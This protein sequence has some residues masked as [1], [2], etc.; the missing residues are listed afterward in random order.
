MTVGRSPGQN[1]FRLANQILD[2]VREA[3]FE[4]GHHLRE[5]QLGD[6]LG[7]SRTPVRMALALLAERG[8]V[9][10]RRN[11]GY[12]LVQP[13]DALTRIEFEVPASAEQDL[14]EK[15]VGD[16]IA[17][18]IPGSLTQSEIARR[19][20]VDRAVMLRTLARLAEDGLVARNKGHG[21]TF[22]PTLDSPATLRASYQFR[23]T[24]EPAGFLMP[25][26][27]ADMAALERCR[28]QHLFLISHPDITEVDGKL[29]YETDAAFHE[30]LAE[31]SGNNFVLQAIQQQNRLRRLLE[32]AGYGNRRRVKDWVRE[33]LAIIDAV[34]AGDL[35]AASRRMQDHL[36]HAFDEADPQDRPATRKP[37]KVAS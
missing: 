19:Y 29:L 30:L 8:V 22:L 10:A 16:R 21:W 5:Q 28:L 4:P 36:A 25:T 26:F 14:F 23:L 31:F 34:A 18:R 24:L 27:R 15:L 17:G 3:R 1:R 7:V 32:F 35:A 12:F 20:G 33:H 2:L 37:R 13:F 9:E 11:Q 6:L